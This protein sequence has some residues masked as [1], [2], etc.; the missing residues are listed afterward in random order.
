MHS[1]PVKEPNLTRKFPL[2][3]MPTGLLAALVTPLADHL[4]IRRSFDEFAVLEPRAG[5]D[6][7][8]QVGRVHGSPA[9][10]GGFDEFEGHRHAGGAGAGSLGDPL[11]QPHGREGRLDGIRG[12]QVQP[13]LGRIVEERGQHV[14][15]VD[16]L[17]H[18]LG[19]LRPYSVAKLW[20]A[21]TA[22]A[23]FSAL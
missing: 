1:H 13:V 6:Q 17:G 19:P 15:V 21:L 18:G 20:A 14:E 10:L 4:L 9:V 11:P 23:L 16:D 8:D 3:D 2:S 5:A 22:A 12:A 7:E